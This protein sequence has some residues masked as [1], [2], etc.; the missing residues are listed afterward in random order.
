[1]DNN[2]ILRLARNPE[3]GKIRVEADL[4]VTDIQIGAVEIKDGA[5]NTRA[6]VGAN[7]L[8]VAVK[9]L[10][11][12][13]ST[14]A[15]Q[16]T[17][18]T[19]IASV[20][21]KIGE[22]QATP[23]ANTLLGRLKD[24][25]TAISN[26]ISGIILS[27]GENHIGEIGGRTNLSSVEFTRATPDA[28]AYAAN[29]AVLPAAGGLAELTNAARVA[30]GSGYITQIRL[31]TNKKSITPR[32]RLHFFNVSNSTLATDNL[33]WKELYA[34]ASKRITYVDMP[35]LTTAADTANSDM[36]RT[37]DATVRVPFQCAVDSTSLW[38]AIETLDAFTPDAAQKFT[39]KINTELN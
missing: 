11:A 7:G 39:I 16:D 38:V 22:V 18:N 26:L 6:K 35:A 15:K 25:A 5:G 1:M 37:M 31:S 24:I 14:S 10:P 33:A 28:T 23:T 4:E 27:A 3:T 29:D 17:G 20:D 36:S 8:E 32:L 12:G 9:E 2:E 13:L 21:T 30:G 19:S 34:D